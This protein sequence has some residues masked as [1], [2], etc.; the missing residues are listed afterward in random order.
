ME[1]GLR[2]GLR[3]WEAVDV[4]RFGKKGDGL[5]L[6]YRVL[7]RLLYYLRTFLL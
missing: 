6:R 3:G 1:R 4:E 5:C 2:F 7:R